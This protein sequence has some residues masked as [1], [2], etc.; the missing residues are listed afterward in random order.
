MAEFRE[1]LES[2]NRKFFS[3]PERVLIWLL[4]KRQIGLIFFALGF[5]K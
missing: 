3:L 5:F 4:Q 1:P 2:F